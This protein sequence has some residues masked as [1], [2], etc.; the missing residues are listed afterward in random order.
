MAKTKKVKAKAR[1]RKSREQ[2]IVE[3]V[4]SERNLVTSTVNVDDHKNIPIHHETQHGTVRIEGEVT[5]QKLAMAEN[6]EK[7]FLESTAE[8][9]DLALYNPDPVL[10]DLVKSGAIKKTEIE[11]IVNAAPGTMFYFKKLGH[12][13]KTPDNKLETVQ[14]YCYRLERAVLAQIEIRKQSESK[15]NNVIE[16]LKG[17]INHRDEEIA[18][19]KDILKDLKS[20]TFLVKVKTSILKLLG[21]E[22]KNG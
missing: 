7:I 5:P 20:R 14:N 13:L 18:I 16:M 21:K 3:K 4:F 15:D 17:E 10:Y 9:E 22:Q 1:K 8:I 12:V 6:F 11:G 2:T 19:L